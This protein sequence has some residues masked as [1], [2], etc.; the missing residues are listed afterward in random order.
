M[1]PQAVPIEYFYWRANTKRCAC[2][3]PVEAKCT[4]TRANCWCSSGDDCYETEDDRN[5]FVAL[6]KIDHESDL[7]YAKYE[8]GDQAIREINFTPALPRTV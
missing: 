2:C 1:A 5:N 4:A 6:R 3:C 7:L 8:A